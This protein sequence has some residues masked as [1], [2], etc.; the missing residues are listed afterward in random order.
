MIDLSNA[1]ILI[2][3]DDGIHAPGLKVLEEIAKS[4]CDD[5]WVVAPETE[6]SAT[7]H[8]LTLRRPLRIHKHG[9]KR[10]SVD[11]T[12]TDCVLLALNEV[13]KDH[14]PNLVLSG[15]NRGGNLGEDVTYSGTIAAAMEATLLG[16]PAIALSQYFEDSD[17]VKW[18]TASTCGADVIKQLVKNT[19]PANT[20]MNVNF[21]DIAAQQVKGIEYTRQGRR[22]IGD[23]LA[24]GLDPRGEEYFWIGALRSE[25]T[26]NEGTDL[27][28]VVNHSISA[29]PISLDF[30]DYAT[31]ERLKGQST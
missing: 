30:T 9:D 8:S 21:P 3:N 25:E 12:P 24:K 16:M 27:Y 14:K 19:W 28:A 17:D 22:K 20:L 2:S 10:F 29:S 23:D 4:I 13:M 15:V 1:R 31:L 18:Q 11:G 6:Q 26:F 5:V 7:G